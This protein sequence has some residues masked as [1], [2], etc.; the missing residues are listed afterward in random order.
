M[1][2]RHHHVSI[3]P[4]QLYS[5]TQFDSITVSPFSISTLHLPITNLV[6]AATMTTQPISDSSVTPV[7]SDSQPPHCDPEVVFVRNP[8][9]GQQQQG[10]L[11]DLTSL[12]I[13][14]SDPE[15]A[16]GIPI[17]RTVKQFGVEAARDE[18]YG[19]AATTPAPAPHCTPN[20]DASLPA[21]TPR[22]RPAYEL[23]DGAHERLGRGTQPPVLKT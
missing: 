4:R 18:S 22:Y 14:A 23:A 15:T 9:S 16:C 11:P 12:Q 21:P 10:D 3:D 5:L 20:K 7:V 17:Q 2:C 8:S 1:E 19:D 13:I 6:V